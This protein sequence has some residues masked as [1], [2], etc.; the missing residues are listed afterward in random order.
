MHVLLTGATGLLGQYLLRDLLQAGTPVAVLI[1]QQGK[2]TAQERLASILTYW[3]RQLGRSL[4]SPHLLEGDISSEGLGLCSADRAW[5]VR[6]CRSVLHNAAS[7]TFVGKDRTQEPWRSNYGGTANVLEFCRSCGL[8]ELHYMSTAYVCGKRQG[9]ILE[10]EL[11]QEQE[12]RN[13]YEHCK[14]EAEKLVRSADFLHQLTVY[15][16]AVI[17]GDSRTGF[18]A[19]YH[20]FYSYLQFAWLARQL[21]P[22]DEQGRFYYPIR[23]TATGDEPR[24]LVP[25]DW[26]S[27]VTAHVFSNAAHHGKT[28]HLTPVHPISVRDLHDH[29]ARY[30][31]VQGTTFIGGQ[32][33]PFEAMNEY[34]KMFYGYVARYEGYW[35]CEPHF[36]CRHTQAAAP[37]LPCPQLDNQCVHRLIEFAVQDRFGKRRNGKRETSSV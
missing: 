2:K 10:D 12:F 35:G 25:V 8:R 7:L 31:Q 32:P 26:V 11:D 14:C 17:T 13:D 15:R 34:E 33:L 23:F 22:L 21:S 18:T 30:F 3:Q 28:Y 20:G 24:N 36:D 16:P 9:T 5:V 27:A 1:R 6:H 4:P 29:F 37:H 19:T